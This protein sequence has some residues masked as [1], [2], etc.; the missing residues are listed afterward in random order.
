MEWNSDEPVNLLWTGGWDSSFR[1]LQLLLI[2]NRT[3]QP[4][5]IIDPHRRSTGVELETMHRI[6]RALFSSHPETKRLLLPTKLKDRFDIQPMPDVTE[7]YVSV[8]E[9]MRISKGGY[10]GH[11][12]DWLT[13]YCAEQEVNAME[14]CI[15]LESRPYKALAAYVE[16]SGSEEEPVWRVNSKFS[17]SDEYKLFQ[18]FVFPLFQLSKQEMEHRAKRYSFDELM[19]ITCFCHEPRADNSPCGVCNPCISAIKEGFGKRI[20]FM[21]RMRYHFYETLLHRKYLKEKY[22]MQ[23][24]DLKQMRATI[25]TIGL[26]PPR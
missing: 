23:V 19:Y 10:L 3:V 14:L 18:Y 6:K 17:D 7:A 2:H 21:G 26:S 8:C 15:E 20:P 16:N 9:R 25:R 4:H 12:Y 24:A 11:Q 22:F 13:R 5:Y 1:L